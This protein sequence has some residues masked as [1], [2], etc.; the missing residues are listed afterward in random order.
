LSQRGGRWRV[1]A[2]LP[3]RAKASI[4]RR[5]PKSGGGD[6]GF[7]SYIAFTPGCDVGVFVA[8]NTSIPP[9]FCLHRSRERFDCESCDALRH[10]PVASQFEVPQW[11]ESG[12]RVPGMTTVNLKV[13]RLSYVRTNMR[14][15]RL[16]LQIHFVGH[17]LKRNVSQRSS[18]PI[19]AP[20]LLGDDTTKLYSIF[21]IFLDQ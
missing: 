3:T 12:A 7:M 21:P 13:S 18:S 16:Q 2:W 10:D 15:A 9:C 19:S 1:S 4:Q 6:V 8:V 20:T 11:M 14:R 5:L 17:A